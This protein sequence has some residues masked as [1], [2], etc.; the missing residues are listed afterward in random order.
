MCVTV[1]M[2]SLMGLLGVSKGSKPIMKLYFVLVVGYIMIQGLFVVKEFMF[3]TDW[4]RDALDVSWSTAYHSNPQLIKDL[5]SEFNCQGFSDNND[6]SLEVSAGMI[7]DGYGRFPS[8]SEALQRVFGKRLQKLGSVILWIR[9]AQLAGVLLLCVLFKY[10]TAED[11]SNM[12]A[13]DLESQPQQYLSAKD[14]KKGYY[15]TELQTEDANARVPLLSVEGMDDDA[16]PQ[17]NVQELD[18]DNVEVNRGIDSDEEHDEEDD[19]D[20]NCML[21]GYQTLPSFIL[22]EEECERER[23][24][25]RELISVLVA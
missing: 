15:L 16:L 11:E 24:R 18:H 10:L 1:V 2:I 13:Q 7:S 23:E 6:R 14:E 12:K 22:K 21:D 5:Q 20:S 3:G 8:C 17:Y 9:L 19:D 25:E 4:I